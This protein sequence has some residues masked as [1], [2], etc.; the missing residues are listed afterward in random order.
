MARIIPGVQVQVVK[1]VLP[2]QLAP[3]GVLGLVGLTEKEVNKVVRASS[4]SR[5]VEVLGPGTAVSM[6]EAI[7][8]LANGVFELVVSPVA[9]TEAKSARI[10]LDCTLDGSKKLAKFFIL[11]SRVKGTWADKIMV[12]LKSRQTAAGDMVLDLTFTDPNGGS[13]VHRNLTFLPGTLRYVADVLDRESSLLKVEIAWSCEVKTK[14]TSKIEP[15]TPLTLLELT[16]GGQK[17]PVNLEAE[18]DND[19]TKLVLTTDKEEKDAK[20][21]VTFTITS[22]TKGKKVEILKREKL[23]LPRDLHSL[24]KDL[25]GI[26]NCQVTFQNIWL[27]Y[28]EASL[29]SGLD[30]TLE[31]GEDDNL[32][33]YKSALERLEN[34]PDV[35]MVLAAV[36]DFS[37]SKATQIYSEVISHCERMSN[38]CKGRIGFGQVGPQGP[39]NYPEMASKLISDRF[40]LIAPHGVVGAVTGMIGSLQYFRSPTFK[41]IAG[42]TDL[43]IDLGVEDQRTL[44]KSHL[45]PVVNQRERGTIV[46]HGLTTDGDQISV[47]RVADR[48]V[49]GVKSISEL[50]IGR[51]N[52]EDGRGALKQK[53]IEFLI[54]MEKEGAIIPSTDGSDPAYKID[55][56][57]SQAD[58]AQGIVRVDLA[59]RP[60]RAIDYIYATILVQV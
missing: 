55:V 39:E 37:E 50:F 16:A 59:V 56:Y 20:E 5:L 28:D 19:G 43:S 24:M 2:P 58:F 44:L 29:A 4:L 17:L 31:P 52:N 30:K 7:Q 47:R 26:K 46:L 34:E 45:L 10:E 53:L 6:P 32:A 9:E 51:L 23:E 36:Q 13:E 60:V 8:A 48:A 1:E 57:S 11:A 22:E 49:R 38:D 35:D 25:N 3:S 12:N 27:D 15:D 42:I 14:K 18:S 33:G 40:V 41:R 54:Q 21:L